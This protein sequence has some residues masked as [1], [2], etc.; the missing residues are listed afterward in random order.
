MCKFLVNRH[1]KKFFNS[2]L[3]SN[4]NFL[5]Y[6][7]AKVFKGL[8]IKCYMFYNN[9]NFFLVLSLLYYFWFTSFRSF[10]FP[11]KVSFILKHLD[12]FS[13]FTEFL[14]SSLRKYKFLKV[15]PSGNFYMFFIISNYFNNPLLR[16]F[17]SFF[18]IRTFKS[19]NLLRVNLLV[20]SQTFIFFSFY[21]NFFQ[22]PFLLWET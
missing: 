7:Y 9:F 15:L 18:K 8:S 5:K 17:Y 12:F 14:Y 3:L 6:T 20:S 2:F 13:V 4:F 16:L 22:L 19:F 10:S 21:F 1:F 11:F